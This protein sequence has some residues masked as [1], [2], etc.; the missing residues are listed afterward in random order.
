MKS[1]KYNYRVLL[2][3]DLLQMMVFMHLLIFI[4]PLKNIS[5]QMIIDNKRFMQITIN[6]KRFSQ[7]IIKYL[8]NYKQGHANKKKC[9]K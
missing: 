7:I 4:K 2:T 8:H 6:K 1:T 3:K 9:K 5:S